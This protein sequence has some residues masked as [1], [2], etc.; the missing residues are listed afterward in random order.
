MLHGKDNRS[1]ALEKLGANVVPVI[2]LR[3]TPSARLWKASMLG[4]QS[5]SKEFW[6]WVDSRF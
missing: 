6:T 3:S 4:L 2:F 1:A 5:K